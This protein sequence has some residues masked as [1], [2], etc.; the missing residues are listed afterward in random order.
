[1]LQRTPDSSFGCHCE[2]I[3]FDSCIHGYMSENGNEA[4]LCLMVLMDKLYISAVS[5][6]SHAW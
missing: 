1:M 6:F 4:M 5:A 3:L 2:S